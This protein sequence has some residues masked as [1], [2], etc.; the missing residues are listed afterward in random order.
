MIFYR[1]GEG[2]KGEI[3]NLNRV[4]RVRP[5]R[6]KGLNLNYKS[7][8][9]KQC[10]I[11][12][13]E[14]KGK[15]IREFVMRFLGFPYS[16]SYRPK[17]KW[18]DTRART[19]VQN[20]YIVV[21]SMNDGMLLYSNFGLLLAVFKTEEFASIKFLNQ[22]QNSFYLYGNLCIFVKLFCKFARDK[23]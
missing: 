16:V 15:Y 20:I 17:E 4:T 7:E 2:G 21:S 9:V 6:R 10:F 14:E 1:G 13:L 5:F 22:N 3:L 12:F 23:Y 11:V 19:F 8:D 18:R